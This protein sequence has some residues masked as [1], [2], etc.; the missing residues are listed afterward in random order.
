MHFINFLLPGILFNNK[1]F[2]IVSNL[3][4]S[5]HLDTLVVTFDE[6]SNDVVTEILSN[7]SCNSSKNIFLLKNIHD[8]EN[9]FILQNILN[10]FED[11]F[12]I[13]IV[14]QTAI[15]SIDN[16]YYKKLFQNTAY[17]LLITDDIDE[18]AFSEVLH[19]LKDQ[20]VENFAILWNWQFNK[21]GIEKLS[22]YDSFQNNIKTNLLNLNN[23]SFSRIFFKT[24]NMNNQYLK[25]RLRFDPPRF[26]KL[27]SAKNKLVYGLGGYDGYVMTL[28]GKMFN[29]KIAMSYK[30]FISQRK[31]KYDL[32]YI[33][34]TYNITTSVPKI[35]GITIL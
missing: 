21:I 28:F 3:I 16:I 19:F 30:N 20:R 12:C 35:K 9:W 11:F 33:Y 18:S 8:K 17:Q 27:L 15:Q 7:I 32:S 14:N 4:R 25:L 1:P 34:Y 10:K 26:V 22:D 13:S 6:Q 5:Y 24:V 2:N 23:M 31:F 29:A